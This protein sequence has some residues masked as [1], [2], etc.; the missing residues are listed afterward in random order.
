MSTFY[1]LIDLEAVQSKAARFKYCCCDIFRDYVAFGTSAG[2][3]HIYKRPCVAPPIVISVSSLINAVTLLSFSPGGKWLILGDTKGLHFIED[4]LTSS[5]LFFSIDTK[6]SQVKS[7]AWISE[8]PPKINR[9]PYVYA[10]DDSGCIW[11]IRHQNADVFATLPSGINQLSIVDESRILSATKNGPILISHNKVENTVSTMPIGRKSPVGDFGGLYADEYKAIFLSRPE[12]KLSLASLEGRIK[13][14]LK[15]AAEGIEPDP[16]ISTD[17]HHL[18][19]CPPFLVSVGQNKM[20]YIIDLTATP[21]KLVSAIPELASVIDWSNHKND[22][23]FLCPNRIC[24]FSVC[25]NPIDYVQYLIQKEMFIEAQNIVIDQKIADDSILERLKP[26]ENPKFAEYVEKLELMNQPKSLDEVDTALFAE[27]MSVPT[28]T[29]E[30]MTKLYDLRS[31]IIVDDEIKKKIENYV[32]KFPNDGFRWID[33]IDPDYVVPLINDREEAAQ[34]VSKAAKRGTSE[35]CKM[36]SK[37]DNLPI[38]A[39]VANSPPIR[40]HNL[41]GERRKQFEKALAE[42][43]MFECDVEETELIES[44]YFEEYSKINENNITPEATHRLLK[45]HEWESQISEC[46]NELKSTMELH[47]I[48]QGTKS[49]PP[50]LATA[51]DSEK[52]GHKIIDRGSDGNANWGVVAHLTV[53]PICGMQHNLGESVTSVSVFPCSH[54][55]HVSCLHSRY[56]PICYSNC[57]H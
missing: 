35:L 23:L 38:D 8:P 55:Y 44:L 18:I 45:I 21:P 54:I 46:V 33:E 27:F 19:L 24:I 42:V 50:W 40:P 20:C 5:S 53:C 29:A 4:P 7:V 3:V 1:T 41:T 11:L 52:K 10:G 28:P 56:C 32:I 2:S 43:D 37:I 17:L 22:V 26:I 25:E 6:G 16:N 47:M 48:S 9:T 39:C 51:I 14:T 12:G 49:I 15:F 31:L 13:V 30:M 36:L 57:M 34:F